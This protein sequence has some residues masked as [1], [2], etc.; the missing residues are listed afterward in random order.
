MLVTFRPELQ[1]PPM[2]KEA[3]IGFSFMKPNGR[4]EYVKIEAGVNRDVTDADWERIKDKSLVKRLMALGA[5]TTQTEA[6][7]VDATVVGIE[8][9]NA[10]AD[11]PVTDCMSLIEA[12][13]DIGQLQKWDAKE[14]RIR[15]KNSINK[16]ITAITEGKG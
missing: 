4:S 3:V 6:V 10:L 15:V 12:S 9:D 8:S 2:A 14:K 13:F 5:L 11:R 16:R 1:N 7:D